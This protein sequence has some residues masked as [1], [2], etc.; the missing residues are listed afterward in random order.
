MY[1]KM[2]HEKRREKMRRWDEGGEKDKM[3]KED[4]EEK[5]EKV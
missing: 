1:L 2:N 3:E 4:A 5:G